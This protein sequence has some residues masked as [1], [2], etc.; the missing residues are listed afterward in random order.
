MHREKNNLTHY[1]CGSL[2]LLAGSLC[3]VSAAAY[4]RFG[5]VPYGYAGQPGPVP[6][7]IVRRPAAPA[8]PGYPAA[9]WGGYPPAGHFQAPAPERSRPA[10]RQPATAGQLRRPAPEA[11]TPAP[12]GG[13][14]TQQP[15]AAG[16]VAGTVLPARL[17]DPDLPVSDK[18]QLFIQTMLP[19]IEEENRRVLRQ[20]AR[21][22]QLLQEAVEGKQPGADAV[23]WLQQLA[24][25][26]RIEG[27]PLQDAAAATALQARVDVIPTGLALAQAANESGWGGS[28]FAQEANN[29]FGIWTYDPGKGIKPEQRAA[30]KSHLVR[31]FDSLR[32]SVRSYMHT[33]NS[34][35]AYKPLRA[36]RAQLRR[37]KQP[38][39]AAVLADG[40]VKYSELGQEYVTLIKSLIR[41]NELERF[42]Y[43]R[44]AAAG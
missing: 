13:V 2:L 32:Q 33:L 23:Q 43:T 19:L 31:V 20:R 12:A 40:L 37:E 41:D 16:A 7:Y 38:L 6:A 26:Y 18:K 21:A 34:H 14:A 9:R 22:L 27:D 4:G 3:S 5:G 1:L 24:E 35:P 44:L 17:A 10:V 30:G 15:A 28:R 11:V 25:S 39:E 36:R 29:V 42:D 8:Y